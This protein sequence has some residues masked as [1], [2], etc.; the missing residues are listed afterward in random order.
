MPKTGIKMPQ[1][2]HQAMLEGKIAKAWKV[3]TLEPLLRRED[4]HEEVATGLKPN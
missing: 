2:L 4:G 3:F 1:E